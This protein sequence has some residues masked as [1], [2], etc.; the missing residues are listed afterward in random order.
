M[1]DKLCLRLYQ[2]RA[3]VDSQPLELVWLEPDDVV[4]LPTLANALEGSQDTSVLELDNPG[5]IYCGA[6]IHR[7]VNIL[8]AGETM[9]NAAVL[10]EVYTVRGL[11]DLLSHANFFQ[12]ECLLEPLQTALNTKILSASKSH[13]R[14]ILQVRPKISPAERKLREVLANRS[15]YALLL[16]NPRHE[17]ES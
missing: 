9:W 1:S 2:H 3:P 16:G 12:V 8:H 13:L 11:V 14:T 7:M 10:R 15:R 17:N 5:G 6:T 4:L